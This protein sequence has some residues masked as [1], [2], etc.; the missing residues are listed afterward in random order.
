MEASLSSHYLNSK[1]CNMKRALV[2]GIGGQDGS[3]LAEILLSHG[4]EVHGLYRRSSTDNLR[5]VRHILDKIQLH[6][7]DLLDSL[8]VSRIIRQV[9]PTEI[10]NEA[11][12]D[13]VG[14]SYSAPGYSYDVTGAAVGRTLE[15]VMQVDPTIKFF[16]PVSATMFG[17]VHP[18]QNESTPF[19]PQSP[20]ACAKVM[21]YYLARY[22]RKAHGMFVCTAILYNH[23]S[24]RRTEDYLLN[25]IAR[26]TTK[27]QKGL[28][29][30][31]YLGNLDL[32]VDIGYAREYMEAAW[33]IM[34]LDEP[35]DFI[36]ATGKTYTIQ[37]LAQEAL[38]H[39]GL[40]RLFHDG[41]IGLDERFYRP[42][43]QPVLT[44]DCSKAESAFSFKLEHDAKSLVK[45]LVDEEMKCS[46]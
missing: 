29:D 32:P 8:S 26:S 39:V 9:R 11:D 30:K 28:Q 34:Q 23:D 17:D 41:L 42:G 37:D 3:Y 46:G 7:G 31:I 43:K 2:L 12:Q 5:N 22:Y 20:Y 21:A 14:W 36:I 33:K 19:D 6:Q 38:D 13:N 45:Y 40:D 24:P 44:G 1:Y 35:D 4:Y 25:K 27:I 16:Q 15:A 10:Y 18:P